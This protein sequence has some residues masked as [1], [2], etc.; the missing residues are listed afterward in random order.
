MN[1]TD[2][3]TVTRNLV[4]SQTDG[5]S[6]VST[7]VVLADVP[8]AFSSTTAAEL[9]DTFGAGA[10]PL[11]MSRER[12]ILYLPTWAQALPF[13]GSSL[14]EYRFAISGNGQRWQAE[15]LAHGRDFDRFVLWAV[16]R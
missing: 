10:V 1:Y 13:P 4:V 2:S 6:N 5:R 8:C 7:V 14:S 15:A 9:T 16:T 3:V 11:E 12:V